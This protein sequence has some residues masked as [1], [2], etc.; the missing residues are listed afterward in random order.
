MYSD[1]VV[2]R[3]NAIANQYRDILYRSLRDVLSQPRYTNTGAGL[4]SLTVDV[5]QGTQTKSPQ[6]VVTFDDHILFMD[7]RRLQWT[8]LPDMKG[9]LA[10][11][12]TKTSSEKEARKL[13]WAV[14]WDKK[15]NDTWK[16]KLWR[17]KGLGP[18]LREMNQVILASYEAAIEQELAQSV[19]TAA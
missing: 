8:K 18:A 4:S 6:L 3:L 17:K 12:E 5:I 10:W 14:A 19:K 9:L 16:P 1:E 11:A 7:K 15:K 2:T 13:A